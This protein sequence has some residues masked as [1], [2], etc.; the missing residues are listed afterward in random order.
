[1][2]ITG[3]AQRVLSVCLVTLLLAACSSSSPAPAPTAVPT[4]VRTTASPAPSAPPAA[5]GGRIA[6]VST[7]D[8]NGEIYVMN[9]DGSNPQRLTHNA[10]WD[11]SPAW[12]PDGTQIAYYT[13][14]TEQAWAIMVMNADGSNPR[15]LT[16]GNTCGCAPFW[17]PDGSQIVFTVD[18]TPTPTCETRSGEIAMI[19]A[20]GSGYHLLT[21][22][23]ANDLYSPWSP[24]GAHILFHS[25]RDGDEELY[26]MDADGGNV[27]QVT[28]NTF[29][30]VMPAWSPDSRRIVFV[31]NRD[32]DDEIYVMNADGR[33]PIRITDHGG[34]DWFPVFSP[35]GRQILF[36]S[37]RGS[38]GI[39]LFVMDAGGTDVR[40]LTRAPGE[41]FSAAWR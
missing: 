31:S 28:D 6:F 7:R 8:G 23:D 30:D 16:E 39:D 13:H 38:T 4:G 21:E 1:M 36:S 5:A 26:M 2:K 37:R 11:G 10:R 3:V 40:Q 15:Q 18:L 33:D 25:D 14:L 9:A 34:P 20:D 29:K 17:S 35:D 27:Q 32:G 41:E 22:N 19:N 24:D 12:S